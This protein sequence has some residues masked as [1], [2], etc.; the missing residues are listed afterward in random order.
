ML[1]PVRF[2]PGREPVPVVQETEWGP[3]LVRTTVE[4]FAPTRIRPPDRPAHSDIDI[5]YLLRQAK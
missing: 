2:T 1:H 5:T 3:W 4:N